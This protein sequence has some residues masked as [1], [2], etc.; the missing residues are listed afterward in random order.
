M[1]VPDLLLLRLRASRGR[2][3]A[4]VPPLR[5]ARSSTAGQQWYSGTVAQQY[6]C[7]GTAVVQQ[8]YHCQQPHWYSSGTTAS[9]HSGKAVVQWYSCIWYSSGT[10][11]FSTAVVQLHLASSGTV[12]FGQQWYSCIWYSCMQ[13]RERQSRP[14][15]SATCKHSE[16]QRRIGKLC[17]CSLLAGCRA[18]PPGAAYTPRPPPVV[19]G[20]PC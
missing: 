1:S 19:N 5:P 6:H 18:N 15:Q 13:S 14:Y 10:V 7:C 8:W 11:A 20:V 16:R 4:V 9:N 17:P 2:A 12:A 3:R